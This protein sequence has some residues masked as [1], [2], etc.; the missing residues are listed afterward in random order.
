MKT[1]FYIVTTFISIILLLVSCQVKEVEV[2][3]IKSFKI[4]NIDKSQITIDLEV[5]IKNPNSFSFT[6]NDVSLDL[7]FNDVPLGTIKKVEPVR[8]EKNSNQSQH[9]IFQLDV[10]QISK[11]S[12]LFIPSLLTNKANIKAKGYIK[13]AKFPFGK[14]I[15]VDYD[16]ST[17]IIKGF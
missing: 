17:K 14:K 1:Y 8:I 9:L 4:V 15:P 12:L 2:G 6:I 5:P 16:K 3:S 10:E 7:S 11:G 13:A